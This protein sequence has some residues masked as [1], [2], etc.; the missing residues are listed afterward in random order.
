MTQIILVRHGQTPWNLDKI[1]RGSKDIPLNDQGRE[2]ARL[3]GEWLQ[4]ETIHAAYASPA[5]PGPGHRP[6]HCPAPQSGGRGPAGAHRSVLRR[7]GG[8]AP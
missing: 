6:R 8:D 5:V 2:E 7:L 1:F 4:G 3:A